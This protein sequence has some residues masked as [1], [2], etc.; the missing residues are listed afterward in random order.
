MEY[1][2]EKDNL[3]QIDVPINAYYGI[4]TVRS[5]NNFPISGIPVSKK[6]IRALAMIKRASAETNTELGFLDIDTSVAILQA[7]DEIKN[8]N[9]DDQFPTDAL[10][11]GAGTSTNM[12]I[13]EVI[14]NRAL[15]ILGF[16]KGDYS[17]I[18]PI[19]QINLH[20][21]TNDVYPSAI[22]IAAILAL[23]DLATATSR[24]QGA[25][26][27][28]ETEF[29][30][31]LTIGRTELQDAVPITLGSEFSGFAEAISRDR[32]RLFKSEERLRMLNIG[33]TAVGTGIT[34]PRKYIFT[35]IEKLR[36]LTGLGVSRSE[37]LIDG[38]ANTDAFVEVAGMLNANAV[39][40]KKI[41]TDLRF[42]HYQKEINLPP[43]QAGSSIMPGKINPVI[44]EAAIST[45]IK[46]MSNVNIITTC[47][48][49]GTLQINEFLP[50][51]GHSLLESIEFLTNINNILADHI[52]N[53]TANA[54]ICKKY[55]DEN[56]ILITAFLPFI[57]YM[58]AEELINTFNDTAE[59]NFRKFLDEKL[60]ISLTEKVLSASN[61]MSLGYRIDR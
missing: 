8:G 9:F 4:H 28:K 20:Q 41:A 22:K 25:L 1:R 32:W 27:K 18:N 60:G 3:G 34:A 5:M 7:C 23:R 16:S 33:G 6:L 12:N 36:Q 43:M 17:I 58:K 42:L 46:V 35:V 45:S 51:L 53:I 38:T 26:Q 10:Q 30:E 24:F 2:I 54:E 11:G 56:I 13:N 47:S 61:L 48:S 57:G 49:M 44:M 40:I 37:N 29:A 19:E 14:A 50:L 21:S 59:T 55:F 39:N 52:D 15:E 31:I